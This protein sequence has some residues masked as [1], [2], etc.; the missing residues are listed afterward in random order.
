MKVE[1]VQWEAL[2]PAGYK[3]RQRKKPAIASG[4]NG[5]A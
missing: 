5:Q 2:P 3:M 4:V 1:V